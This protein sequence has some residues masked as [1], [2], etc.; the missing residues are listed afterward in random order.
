MLRLRALR[1]LTIRQVRSSLA[2]LDE[3]VEK[4]GELIVTR[5]GHPLARILPVRPQR[6]IP[7]RA[8]LRASIPPVRVPS[9]VL[10][11]EDR[12]SR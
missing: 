9:E 1:T 5:H 7:T 11:R 4:E 10:I 8:A 12:E 2:H 6:S 3:L